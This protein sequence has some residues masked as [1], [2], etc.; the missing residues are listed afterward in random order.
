M[1]GVISYTPLHSAPLS[2]PTPALSDATGCRCLLGRSGYP[3]SY[4][5]AAA[6]A[7]TMKAI[8]LL[9]LAATAASVAGAEQQLSLSRKTLRRWLHVRYN[10]GRA[11]LTLLH[12]AVGRPPSGARRVHERRA[13]VHL[14]HLGGAVA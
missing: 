2:L 14:K 4:T 12:T 9:L 3:L 6:A 1:V 7:A 11:T 10:A 5:H 8:A 13:D